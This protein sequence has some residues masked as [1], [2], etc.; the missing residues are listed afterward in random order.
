MMKTLND[1]KKALDELGKEYENAEGHKKE[2]I[3]KSIIEEIGNLGESGLSKKK[4]K[5]IR[6]TFRSR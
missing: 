2:R 1:I 4:Y 6:E 5:E 3:R